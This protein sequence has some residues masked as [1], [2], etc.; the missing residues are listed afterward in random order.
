[1]LTLREYQEEAIKAII[2]AWGRGITRQLVCLPTGAGKTVLFAALARKLNHRTLVIAHRE[3]LITQAGD[4]FR[5]V[6][7]GVDIGVCMAERNEV[8]RQVVVA[9]VQ[10]AYRER[11]LAQLKEQGF[12]LLVVDEAHHATAD[13]YVA[14]IEGLGF[15]DDAPD[16]L[17]V[18]VTATGKRG[19]KAPLGQVFQEI[20]FERSLAA[21]VRAGYLADL[22]GLRVATTTSLIGV[23]IR[24][25]GDFAEDELAAACNTAERNRIIV[26]SYLEHA[27]ERKALAFTVDVQHAK[28]L[29][30]A[31]RGADVP[32]AAVWGD[33]PR[34]ERHEVL[35]AFAAG[36]LRVVT[37]CN[38]LT[39]GFDE[40][41]IQALLMARPTKSDVLYTQM[42]GR[43]TRPW[44][45]KE[46][47]LVLDFT[48]G[49]A[50]VC[51]LATLVGVSVRPRQ[52]VREALAEAEVRKREREAVRAGEIVVAAFDILQQSRFRWTE[53]PG[54]HFRLALGGRRAVF[55]KH[56]GDN[57]Y[58]VGVVE[59]G[60]V[61]EYLSDT[62]L[63]LGYAQ[64]V[65]ED[66]AR[67][68]GVARLV[69]KKAQWRAA[70]ATEKQLAAL[71]R[72]GIRPRAGITRGEAS[73]LLDEAIARAEALRNRPATAKQI[74]ALRR[75]GMT[76]PTSLTMREAQ[77]LFNLAR[78]YR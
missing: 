40:P 28:D 16:R 77:K 10:T 13:S 18:G 66:Y 41:S 49:G 30:A 34:E 53:I 23:R 75:M 58:R 26:E 57:T 3:E 7:P 1:V 71:T 73:D 24:G 2:E 31:F 47:C 29:A 50:E 69:D 64:G 55:L 76:V 72:F 39:E 54:G 33:M 25:G 21:M 17:L 11:R 70:P 37:N 45:G 60:Q 20:T 43:G 65:A 12:R 5:L 14:V 38:L 78:S 44:P 56:L 52:S 61:V 27:A 46:D 15:M 32:A 35:A 9:S 4:K 22:R 19:D 67:R 63:S 8:D 42:V 36:D 62:A 6:W 48:D 59:D 74:A 51:S 68:V